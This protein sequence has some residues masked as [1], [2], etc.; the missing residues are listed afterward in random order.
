MAKMGRKSLRDEAMQMNVINLSWTTISRALA[1]DSLSIKEK[2]FIA[3]EIV[4]KSCPKE[5]NLNSEAL[6]NSVYDF[7][8]Q[9]QRSIGTGRNIQE[10]SRPSLVLDSGDGVDKG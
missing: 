1:S 10:N 4:K 9:L 5:I 3:L 2:R 8:G 7:I 6:K